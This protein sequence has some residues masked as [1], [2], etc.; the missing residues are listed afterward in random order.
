MAAAAQPT[1]TTAYMKLFEVYRMQ[2]DSPAPSGLYGHFGT[3]T[4]PHRCPSDTSAPV[5]K[6]PSDISAPITEVVSL[7]TAA[8]TYWTGRGA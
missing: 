1:R 3:K 8:V 7:S 2:Y 6:Y 5:P 4:L